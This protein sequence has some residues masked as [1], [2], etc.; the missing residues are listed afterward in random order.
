MG[1][2][3]AASRTEHAGRWHLGAG[4]ERGTIP[5]ETTH[6]FDPTGLS[7]RLRRREQTRPAQR[8]RRRDWLAGRDAVGKPREIEQQIR[9]PHD[10]SQPAAMVHI[11]A[12]QTKHAILQHGQGCATCRR[13][14]RSACV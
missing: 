12:G 4:V 5:R 14:R 10:K 3:S 1:R 9:L 7:V 11:L 13:P 8:Q 2:E 6:R